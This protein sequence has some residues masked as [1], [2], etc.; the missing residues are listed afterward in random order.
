MY[1]IFASQVI[2]PQKL[3]RMEALISRFLAIVILA[4]II[5]G[6]FAL[7][8]PYISETFGLFLLNSFLISFAVLSLWNPL[9]T[10]FRYLGIKVLK[11]RS[12]KLS[13]EVAEFK[14]KISTLSDPKMIRELTSQTIER[15]TQ[16]GKVFLGENT[17]GLPLP[18]NV[19]A[20]FDHARN[21]NTMPILHRE[22]LMME[23]DQAMVENQRI[24]LG[25]LIQFLD[26]Q[27]ADILIPAFHQNLVVM[28]T[29]I[30]K[31]MP[32]EDLSI[33]LSLYETLYE[34]LQEIA[35]TLVRLTLVAEEKEHDRL[36]LLGEM[37]AGLAHEVRNPLG[38]IRGALELIPDSKSPW[39]IVIQEEVA[40]LNRLVSQFLD[41]AQDPKEQQE[42]IELEVVAE[43]AV[44]AIK[45][46]LPPGVKINLIVE[47]VPTVF[48][49]PDHVRQVL[50]NLI[51]NAVKA[52]E[53][54]KSPI[55]EVKVEKRKISVRDNGIGMSDEVKKKVFQPFFTSFKKG[56]GLGLSICQRLMSFNGG[57]IRIQ[58]EL[59]LGTTVSI[60]F[61]ATGGQREE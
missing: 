27:N 19:R 50:I 59:G 4:L 23:Q 46:S 13:E 3:L 47:T 48:A 22:I 10:F 56:T 60:L 17:H 43:A 53:E 33:N 14:L 26:N 7:L 2:T 52:T 49:V 29:R 5:T 61:P 44:K 41:F 34:M 30:R 55:I 32:F 31:D 39:A 42:E 58:S 15:W 35:T 1:L 9:V 54:L 18:N 24:N 51:Q 38:A 45:A 28:L 6:F 36:V 11:S 21:R 12:N 57:T 37:S 8:Y 25:A 20:Y 16:G 40:R